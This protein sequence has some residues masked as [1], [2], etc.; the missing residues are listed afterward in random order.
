MT[1]RKVIR[2]IV[3]V[4]VFA[5]LTAGAAWAAPPAGTL[6]AVPQ[7][8]MD[9][10][11]RWGYMNESGKIVI[12]CD[13]SAAEP[14]DVSGVAAVYNHSGEAALIDASGE[15]LT[16]WQPAPQ[17]VE[18]QNGIA[19][20]RYQER[21]VYFSNNGARIGDYAGA[22]GFPSNDRVCV[23]T[24][25]DGQVRYGYVN[26]DG[27]SVIAPV[28]REAGQFVDG[29]ALVRDLQGNCHLIG[30]DGRELTALPVGTDPDILQ[31]YHDSV[32]ILHNRAEQDALYSVA[33]M[34]FATPY[35]Y[36]EIKPFDDQCAMIRKGT[37]WGLLRADGTEA[38]APTYPYMSY[39]GGGLY[40]V[41]GVDAGASVIDENG[42]VVY[43]TETYAGGF[44]TFRYGISWHGTASGDVIFFNASGTLKKTVSGIENPE[45]VS[46]TVARVVRDGQ[47][48][49]INIYNGHKLYDN[50]RAYELEG[51]I[52]VKTETYEK[53]LGMLE[54]GTEYGWHITYP[55]LSGM[56][57]EAVQTRINDHIRAF[58]TAGPNG[59]TDRIALNATY[60]LSVENQ[61]LVVWASGVSDV[62][63]AAT[64]WNASIGLDLKTGARYTAKNDL[65]NDEM[66]AVTSQLLPQTAP[67][68][69]A[70]RMDRNGVTF[71]RDYPATG[72]AQPYTESIHL[73]FSQLAQAI[74]FDGACFRALTGFDGAV[75][76]DVPYNHWAFSDISEVGAQ[77]LMTGDANG[78]RPDEPILTSEVCAAVA[79]ALQLEDG[80]MPGVDAAQWYAGELGAIYEAGLFEGFD[81]Y[82]LEP[83]AVMCR[84]D[85]I[86]LLANVLE[87][88]KPGKQTMNEQ[89][90]QALLS[91]FPDAARIADNRRMAVAICV[92]AELILGD[93][94]GIRP[95]DPFTRAEFAK[96]L[97]SITNI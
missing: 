91:D 96:I 55:S 25:I 19:A 9:G 49:Y 64:P 33:E 81:V 74:R 29:R 68:Y 78:F 90:V 11:E 72:N 34:R 67:Y 63:E 92:D 36:D 84:A 24:K 27:V 60:G 2:M 95:D 52:H 70:P 66:F 26:L 50:V 21:T 28:Y 3:L 57:D 93:E 44:Q 59:Q 18:Y 61:V 89:Q 82:W 14:F 79:R 30:T 62:G 54:D 23:R 1:F 65:F 87:Y 51:G 58:F 43:R 46:M 8:G 13:Y 83:D 86:Q 42:E 15:N 41:R 88:Q 40:A 17:L 37:N 85:A 10:I 5:F 7:T 48:E 69:G 80:V 12:S 45:I 76:P 22:I 35:A 47:I 71:F 16:G 20:F 73:T 6:F 56:K 39:M 94:N 75:Y 53:Y 97:R 77:G 38:V 4:S 31:I 32:I